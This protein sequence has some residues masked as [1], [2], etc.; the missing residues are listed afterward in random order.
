FFFAILSFVN[1][2]VAQYYGA[3]NRK[4]CSAAVWQGIYIA[5]GAYLAAACLIPFGR[6]AFSLFGHRAEIASLERIYYTVLMSASLMIML[7][8]TLAA[9]FTG[10]GLSHITMAANVIG[11][12]V[13]IILDWV[14][15][16]GHLGA[17]RLGILGAALATAIAWTVPPAVMM[18]IFLRK[19]HQPEYKTRTAWR[20]RPELIKRLFRIGAPSGAND[21]TFFLVVG[22]F[23]MFMGRTLPESLAANNMA[24]SLND[25]LT[26]YIHG[27][28]LAATTIVAQCIGSGR[29]DEAERVV[30]LVLKILLSMAAL[31]AIVYLTL[32]DMLFSLFRVRGAGNGP[33]NVPFELILPRG[34]IIL[35]FFICYNF[36]FAFVYCF[37]QAVRGAG[38]TGYF[39]KVALFVDVLIF[40]P[41]LIAA[42]RIFGCRVEVLW[43]FF[44]VYT[45]IVGGV[46]FFRFRS[47]IWKTLDTS[48]LK[49]HV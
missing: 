7:N 24:W 37:R 43:S 46:H 30:Y 15:I 42:V 14:L 49:D 16:F 22:L 8:H 29:Y 41:G 18:A 9:F 6:Q 21:L 5:L 27:F 4:M 44:L 31:I 25:L 26:L 23:F 28:C 35:L 47:G 32:P 36:F 38:D 19:D 12:V 20:L 11:N 1:V 2:F 3:G 48:K 17:P 10:R 13:N 33:G 39:L 45:A 34:R 40:I